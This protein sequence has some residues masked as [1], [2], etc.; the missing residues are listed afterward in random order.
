[1][2]LLPDPDAL[3][4]VID[5]LGG[6]LTALG[7]TA[8]VGDLIRTG[9]IIWNRHLIHMNQSFVTLAGT[10]EEESDVNRGITLLELYPDSGVILDFLDHLPI[11]SYDHTD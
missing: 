3:Q 6:V 8:Y 2:S 9:P 5:D 1:M 10:T 7:G 11:A 4:Q